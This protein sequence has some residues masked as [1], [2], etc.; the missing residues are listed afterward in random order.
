MPA[1][2]RGSQVG[3]CNRVGAEHAEPLS[4]RGRRMMARPWAGEVD[5]MT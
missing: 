5:D 1:A 2:A 3:R 4:D